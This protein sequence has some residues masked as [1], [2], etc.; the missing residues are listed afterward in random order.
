MINF[1]IHH[2]KLNKKRK[3]KKRKLKCMLYIFH[4]IE[5]SYSFF[6]RENK[7]IDDNQEENEEEEE[8][9]LEDKSDFEKQQILV[10]TISFLFS[11]ILLH[12]S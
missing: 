12:F 9:N 2:Q 4:S 3:I 1:L 5:S 10:N 7:Y 11:I 8:I 6:C